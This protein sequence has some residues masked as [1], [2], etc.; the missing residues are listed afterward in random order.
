MENFES[1]NHS[2][3]FIKKECKFCKCINFT[4]VNCETR[5]KQAKLNIESKVDI[6]L[7]DSVN[8]EK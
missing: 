4:R 1:K 5:N 3:K 6:K 8:S 7:E 2:S